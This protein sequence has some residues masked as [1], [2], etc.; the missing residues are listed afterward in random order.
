MRQRADLGGI[1]RRSTTGPVPLSFAQQRLWF[2]DQLEP[3]GAEYVMPFGL[4]LTGELDIPALETA[5]SGLVARHEIL[6]TR[7]VA[8]GTGRPEQIVDPQ[9]PLAVTVH[10]LRRTEDPGA[11]EQAA[12]EILRTEASRPFDLAVGPLLRA[13]VVRLAD[14]EQYLLLAMHHIVSDGWSEAI[15]AR[16]LRELYSAAL[17]QREAVLPA[18][19]VQY[20]DFSLWQRQWLTGDTLDR[21]LGYWRDHL[22]G[23][24]PLELPTDRRRPAHHGGSGDAIAFSVP[25][26]ITDRLKSAAAGQ[27]ASLFMTLLS[28]FQLLL[29]KYSGQED[30]AVGTPIAGRNRAEIEGAIG[31]FVNTLVMR[32]DLSGDPTFGELLDRVKDT[33]LSAYDHQDLPFERLV[34]ELAPDRDLSRNPLF[35]TMLVLQAQGSPET[36]D[37]GAWDLSGTRSRPVA[38]K[39]GFAKFDL[40]LNVMET[41]GGLEASLEYRTDLFESATMAR[42]VGH[43]QTLLASV[44]GSP[45][46]RLSE[47][48]MLTAGE[49]EQILVEWNDTAGPYPDAAT[50]H[51]LV[52]ERAGRDPEAV[53]VSF[54][55]ESLTYRQ[56][57]ERANQ[58]AHHLRGS[59]VVPGALVAVCLD[60]S[61]DLVCALLGILKAGAAFVPLDPDYPTER[62]AYMVEDTATPLVVTHTDHAGRLPAGT[63][64]LLVDREWP[65]G[66]TSDP[67]PVAG[68]DDAA[69]VIYTSGSTGRP[70]GVQLDHRGVVNYLDWCDRNY[71]PTAASGVGTLLYSSVTFDLT[72]TAL[73]LPLMQ[74]LRIDIPR[75]DADQSA[76]DA[77]VETVLTGVEVSFLKATPSHLELLVAQLESAGVRHAIRTVVAGGEDLSPALAERVLAS[78]GVGT[79]I[80]NEYGATEGSVANVM[81]LFSAVDPGWEAT[82]VGVP[83]SNTTAYVVDR[84]D[85]PVPVGVPGECLLGGICVAR[86]YL[87]RA[88]LTGERF[89]PDPFSG[90]PGARV[91]RTGDLVVWRADGQMEFVGRI[92]DQVKLRGYRIELGEIENNLLTHPGISAT[93]VVVREDSPGDKRL[94]AYLVPAGDTAPAIGDLRAHLQRDLPDYMVPTSYVTLDA[95]PL[96]PNGKTDR[97]ALPAPDHHRPD[98]D[99]GYTAPRSRIEEEIVAIWQ[100]VLGLAQVGIH[101]NFFQLGGHSLLATRVTSRIRSGLGIDVPVRTL[102]TSP[103]PAAFAAAIGG[104]AAGETARLAP[105]PRDGGPLPLS[106]AQQRL[107]FLDQL[108]PGSAEYLVPSGLRIRGRLDLAALDAALSGLV[109]RHEILRTRFIADSDGK[110]AQLIDPAWS[111]TTSVHDL[112]GTGDA[113]AREAAA[114]RILEAEAGRPFD[115]AVGPLLRADVVRLADEDQYLLL[116]VHHIVSDGWSE[117]IIARELREFYAAGLQGREPDLPDLAVQY[118]DFSVWQRQWLTG[119]TLDGQLDYWRTRLTG[120]E[121]LELPTDHRRPA[122]RGTEGDAIRFTVPAGVAERIKEISAGQGA[123]LFMTLLSV[124]QLLLSKYSGQED[125]AVGTPIAGRNRAEIEDMIGFFVNTLV[126]RTDLSGDPTFTELLNRVK[127]TAI[128]AYDHQDLPFERLVDE[129]APKRDLSRNPLFQTMLVLQNVSEGDTWTLPDLEVEPVG[130]NGQEVKFDCQLT[131]GETATGLEASLEYRTDLFESATMARLVGHFQTLLASVADSPGARLSELEM[132]TAGEREQILVE[133]ND[134]AG[135]YP[136]A[137]TIHQLVEERAGRDPEAVAVSF[138]AESLTYRQVNERANQLAHHLRGSGVTPGMLVAVCLDRSPDLVCALLGILKAGAAYVPLDPDYPTERIAYMVED[139]ATPLIVTHT[140]HVGRLPAGVELLLADRDWPQGATSDPVP[141]AGPDDP[142]YVIYT[143]GSTGRPKGVQLDHRGVVN[144]LD[145]CDKNYPPTAAGSIGTLLYSS[146]T[147][148][149][150]VTALFLPLMQGLRIDIP[151]PDADQSAFDAAVETVL[152]GVEISFLK[153]TPSHLELLVAQLEL[154][155]VRH[156]IRT[157]VAGGEDLSPAL[158][159]RVLASSG[160]GTVISNEYGAT[161]GSVANVMSLFSAVD[162]G[163]EATPVGVPISNTTAY[164]VDRFD[165]P[166]PVGVPGE[167]LLGGICVARGYLNRPELT[168]ARFV[169]DPFSGGPGA[170]VYRTGDL[171][172]W[173]ADGQMEFV[174]RIDDQVKLRGYR[175]ELGEIENNLLTH[176][177]ISAT[178]VVVREDSPGDKRLVAYLV[179][180]GD[181]APAIGDLRAHLQRDLPDYM[182]PTSYVTLEALPLTP[183]GKTDRKALPAP[184]HHR[185]D[186]DTGYTAPT[187]HIE[188]TLATVWSEILGIDPIGIHDNFFELGGDS[189]VSIQMIARAKKFGVHLTPRMIF[190]HQTIAEIA[191][192]AQADS[193]VDAEQGTVLGDVALTPIQHW[194]FEKELPDSHHFNQAEL[195]ETDDLDPD[196]LE[197]ALH[198]LIGHHDALRL[199]YDSGD[200]G[201]SQY[202]DDPAGTR[203]LDVHDLSGLSDQDLWPVVGAIGEEVQQSLDLLKGPLVRSALLS[204]GA[205]RGQ[206]LLVAV[207]HLAVDGVS[208]RILLEDLGSAYERRSAGKAP[209]LPAKTTSFK[210]WA[211][212]LTRFAVSPEAREEFAY[213]AEPKP[214]GRIP[215]DRYGANEART[216]DT[217]TASLSAKET[218]A[219]LRDIPRAFNTQINDVLLTALARA[220]A[221][222]TGD[223][224]TLIGLEGHGREDLFTDVDLSRTVGWFTSVFPVALRVDRST[225]AVASLAAVREQLARIPNKG[226]GYGILR[227]LGSPEMASVLQE[228]S[229]PEVNFNYLGQFTQQLPGIGRY[230]DPTEPKGHSISP[231]GMRWNVLDVT[232]AV[233][234]DTFN[235]Y[236]NYS[237]AL[238]DRRTVERLADEM[239]VCLRDLIAQSSSAGSSTNV[240]AGRATEGAPLTDVNDTDMAAILERFSS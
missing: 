139:T 87:N 223:G 119:D 89:V 216:A 35:Q 101:D 39:R 79:V 190:K 117:G 53:A 214:S 222:W 179:P 56:V 113:E 193:A 67:V 105:A 134:T 202:L 174:G 50:I 158:A 132:L 46:A 204:L 198:D 52:E 143:S 137:A 129:L 66:A 1:P 163:W 211:E 240:G 124:F 103:T 91:Y 84:F 138:G 62:I 8:D 175:I 76:F 180:A 140:D 68:P 4:H 156:A 149:L 225:D 234:G 226:V 111:V 22:A 93:A 160:V 37:G 125:I 74:G 28:V 230:A 135:P 12:L 9:Q 188:Q 185:P 112:R 165:R 77:A 5:L 23:V 88:E 227:Y 194:F 55:A 197:L 195:L 196:A 131:V 203:L 151:R 102:F 200:A 110:P 218:G 212:K 80:S 2:L 73:F 233:E 177:G 71:P 64:L 207:H 34:E 31:F 92:D 145:W 65:Q 30:I 184:D 16:E 100:D 213:W 51:Q 169:A 98:L 3:G 171:V 118:G 25:A 42:L 199:R 99:T 182:V 228:Q 43:F 130:I 108:E 81:S 45:G 75:P 157:V 231:N 109:A 224:H 181:T 217:V 136:D 14:Q 26:E 236:I 49:R 142:A 116:T 170:R 229:S 85:R 44:A 121:P 183:N 205:T 59:G 83:I 201:W 54:G 24:A 172:V 17:Q 10:D 11:R 238:H 128:G 63:A 61:P 155:G 209:L 21:Q 141:V 104:L 189:I 115:L 221:A 173:R 114:Q 126:M 127:D 192:H 48:E 146:V 235:V 206:R 176:P 167:C 122:E 153:A 161:E 120:L 148:D 239:T 133:W 191:A 41:A 152:T 96:T 29:S 186:L 144:Y 106:F 19:P 86:G 150:T 32:T 237:E 72:I 36:D 164:V 33:A 166:V 178:A 7:F 82:P 78:S 40:T 13:D 69:Y 57:N 15:L 58:L 6:R 219:L 123:S 90:V 107:W 208:W 60:R 159:E 147:F 47:L 27:G 18:L 162:P 215:R 154:A 70:K 220:L 94:V 232:A 210:A 20:A 168:G 97:K 187:N 38:I 95:L